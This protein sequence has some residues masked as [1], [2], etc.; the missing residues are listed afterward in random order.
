[1]CSNKTDIYRLGRKQYQNDQAIVIA[2]DVEH[3]SLIANSIYA[4]KRVSSLLF[5]GTNIAHYFGNSKYFSEIL[6]ESWGQ[7]LD[8]S[9]GQR[10]CPHDSFKHQHYFIFFSRMCSS[11]SANSRSPI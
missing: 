3:I 10:S 2:F 8:P 1:M 6:N 4:V 9:L 7:A 5:L 11:Y